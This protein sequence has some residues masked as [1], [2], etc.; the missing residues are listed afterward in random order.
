MKPHYP[1]FVISH[2]ACHIVPTFIIY[3]PHFQKQLIT[4]I[5][6]LC[7]GN[8]PPHPTRSTL[9]YVSI[10]IANISLKDHPLHLSGLLP[11]SHFLVCFC[12]LVVFHLLI[13]EDSGAL[14]LYLYFR[15]HYMRKIRYLLYHNNLSKIHSDLK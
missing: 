11:Q 1:P 5:F 14:R 6:R 8:R 13:F 15:Q 9:E 10:S 4:C 3:I 7:I 2:I 12:R